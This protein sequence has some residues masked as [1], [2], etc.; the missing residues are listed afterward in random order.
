MVS[1]FKDRSHKSTKKYRKYKTLS[2]ILESVDTIVIF[3]AMSTSI[4]LSIT[5]IGLNLLPKAAGITCTLSLCNKVL[6]KLIINKYNKKKKN[7][8]KETNKQIK[9]SI[10]YVENLYKII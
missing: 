9:L 3:G 7:Y 2:T 8:M 5:G 4:T 6:Q 1:Y 10:I